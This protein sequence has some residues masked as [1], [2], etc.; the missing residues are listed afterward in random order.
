MVFLKVLSGEAKGVRIEIDQD[1]THIGRTHDNRLTIPSTAASSHHCEVVRAGRAYTIRDLNSTNGTSLNGIMVREAR[2]KPEDVITV[3]G[4]EILFDGDDVDVD[5]IPPELARGDHRHD[6]IQLAA[7]SRGNQPMQAKTL[8]HAQ[9]G[10]DLAIG[11]A[12]G[13]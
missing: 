13:D 7:G 9:H 10:G 6:Q 3:G 8:D 4:I 11:Q 1:E 2:L 12:A 5:D